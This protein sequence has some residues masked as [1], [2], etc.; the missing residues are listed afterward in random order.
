MTPEPLPTALRRIPLDR[1]TFDYTLL[2]LP[3]VVSYDS[4][5]LASPLDDPTHGMRASVNVVPTHSLG[6]SQA[7]FLI[8]TIKG[9]A[10]FDLDICCPPSRDA[11]C[12]PPGP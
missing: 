6:H 5:D 8:T 10:Y 9:A 12:S 2:G 11:A 4:T 7:T 3:L 1:L